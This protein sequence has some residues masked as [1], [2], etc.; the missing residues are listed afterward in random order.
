MRSMPLKC[1]QDLQ[2]RVL[3]KGTGENYI[4]THNCATETSSQKSSEP[5]VIDGPHRSPHLLKWLHCSQEAVVTVLNLKWDRNHISCSRNQKKTGKRQTKC[6]V[7]PSL[8]LPEVLTCKNFVS[9]VWA[10]PSGCLNCYSQLVLMAVTLKTLFPV[11]EC[12]LVV[13][14][15]VTEL[16]NLLDSIDMNLGKFQ[17][18]VRGREAWRAAVHGISKSQTRLSDWTTQHKNFVSSNRIF[19]QMALERS[20]WHNFKLLW[21]SLLIQQKTIH[22][23][24][25]VNSSFLDS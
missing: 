23:I 2:P 21:K 24:V 10:S 7:L 20:T 22:N 11:F 25:Y 3:L 13:V 18:I 9:S 17:E 6:H 4:W 14:S 5:K 19:K 8:F 1:L 15:I 12:H 16:K